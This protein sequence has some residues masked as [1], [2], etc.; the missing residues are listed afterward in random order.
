MAQRVGKQD[1]VEAQRLELWYSEAQRK[2]LS[3]NRS[4]VN[5]TL[6]SL[7]SLHSNLCTRTVLRSH[8]YTMLDNL[9]HSGVRTALLLHQT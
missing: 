6:C 2:D 8:N 5:K 1:M 7:G 3:Q 4:L 9:E